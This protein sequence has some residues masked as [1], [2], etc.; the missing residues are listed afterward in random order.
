MV[1]F[2]TNVMKFLLYIRYTFQTCELTEYQLLYLHAL[3]SF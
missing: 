1:T 3:S 2:K